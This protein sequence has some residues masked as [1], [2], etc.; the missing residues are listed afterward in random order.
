MIDFKYKIRTFLLCKKNKFETTLN[1]AKLDFVSRCVIPQ[2]DKFLRQLVISKGL[3]PDK[4]L[5]QNKISKEIKSVDIFNNSTFK[6]VPSESVAFVNYVPSWVSKSFADRSMH[7]L[8]KKNERASY[9]FKRAGAIDGFDSAAEKTQHFKSLKHLI[10]S[11]DDKFGGY[12][13]ECFVNEESIKKD[14]ADLKERIE[15]SKISETDVVEPKE[16]KFKG[17]FRR[18]D[19]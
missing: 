10:T 9:F 13:P 8:F 1:K 6:R 12:A 14:L 16:D 15:S 2:L 3:D 18:V 5:K 11:K 4:N 19:K 17:S 7:P